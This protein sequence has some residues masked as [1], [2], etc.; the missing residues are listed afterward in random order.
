MQDSTRL[1][2]DTNFLMDLA[3]PEDVAQD[4]LEVIH[5]KVRGPQL[6][7]TTTVL[8]ETFRKA[9]KAP[10]PG[11]RADAVRA[12]AGMKEW[13]VFAYELNDLHSIIARAVANNLLAEGVIPPEERNDALI[14]AEAAV[15]DCQ[16]LVSSDSHLCRAN[17]E[18]LGQVLR[19]SKVS[20]VM[21]LSPK[22]IVRMFAGK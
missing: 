16:L 17:R 14:I 1:A 18:R 7:A 3:H 8:K 15:L 6:Y 22:D 10:D 13:G 12:I 19:A 21:V 2:V 9:Q 4:A 11:T 20:P 5:R